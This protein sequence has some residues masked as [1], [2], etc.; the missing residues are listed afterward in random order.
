MSKN[1]LRNKGRKG[2]TKIEKEFLSDYA[3]MSKFFGKWPVSRVAGDL[4]GVT[5]QAVAMYQKTRPISLKPYRKPK[6]VAIE[7]KR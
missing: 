5:R 7:E 2:L 4:H 1:I 6:P 3:Y